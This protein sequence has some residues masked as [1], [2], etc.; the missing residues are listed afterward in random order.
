MH[1]C[2]GMQMVVNDNKNKSSSSK[3]NDDYCHY[4]FTVRTSG[5][6]LAS[7][8]DSTLTFYVWDHYGRGV[9]VSQDGRYDVR[10]QQ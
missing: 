5:W 10:V 7:G 2:I 8:T 9:H 6:V 1:A 4:Q 3:M